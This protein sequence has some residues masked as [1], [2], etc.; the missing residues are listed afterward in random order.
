M[1]VKVLYKGKWMEMHGREVDGHDDYEFTHRAGGREAVYMIPT[2][3]NNELIMILNHRYSVNKKVLEFPAGLMDEG[4][5]PF[6]TANRELLEETG[7]EANV[8]IMHPLG[9]SN[10]GGSDEEVWAARMKGCKK[11]S[12]QQLDDGENIEVLI[13][14]EYDLISTIMGYRDLGFKISSRV[15]AYMIGKGE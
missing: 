4:E 8:V 9:M 13:I 1:A 15:I 5:E 12:E 6:H 2:T 7:Y 11:I 10:S 3:E 14:P